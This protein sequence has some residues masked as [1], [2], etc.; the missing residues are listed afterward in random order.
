VVL[1]LHGGAKNGFDP[2]GARSASWRRTS[3]MR[4]A[5]DGPLLGEGVAV[6]LLR[7]AVR[8][9]N[10]GHGPE[11]SPVPDALWALDEVAQEHPGVPVVLL[12]HSMGARTAVHVA[13]HAAVTGVIGLAAW[14]ER[15]DPVHQ[16]SGRDLV[17]AHGR[18][19]RITSPRGSSAYVE[20]ARGVAASA[21]FVDV[22][23]LGHYMLRG[24][25]T[26]NRIALAA[27]LDLVDRAGRRDGMPRHP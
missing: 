7:F 4:N 11:P 6:W 2:V 22:G 8:G 3:V 5:L 26:W 27:S 12:G 19:D 24:A 10:A 14:L 23:P 16:L 9:W 13:D 17:L 21:E 15:S 20:R 18:R 1:M 25:G